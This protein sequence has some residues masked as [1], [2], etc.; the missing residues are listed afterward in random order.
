MTSQKE[1]DESLRNFC[2]FFCAWIRDWDRTSALGDAMRTARLDHNPHGGVQY[3]TLASQVPQPIHIHIGKVPHPTACAL[4]TAHV[5]AYLLLQR[6]AEKLGVHGV[7]RRL[8]VVPR[9]VEKWIK[10][11]RTPTAET[12]NE[13]I[14]LYRIEVSP[15]VPGVAS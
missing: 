12:K 10:A 9:T 5:P 3:L 2:C 7:A 1:R 8:H 4:K 15:H 6:L 11:D 14:A 13:I